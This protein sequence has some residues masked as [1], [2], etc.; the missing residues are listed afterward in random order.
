MSKSLE[1]P[2]RVRETNKTQVETPI[3]GS[4]S[5]HNGNFE[6]QDTLGKNKLSSL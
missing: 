6:N 4:L 1:T 5:S 3:P 2:S